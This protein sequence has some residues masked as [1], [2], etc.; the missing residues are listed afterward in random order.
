MFTRNY[1]DPN[2]PLLINTKEFRTLAKDPYVIIDGG[3]AGDIEVPFSHVKSFSKFIRFEPRGADTID[4]NDDIYVDGGLWEE[5]TLKNLHVAKRRTTSS[6][7]PPNEE[8]LKQFDN[9]YGLPPRTTEFKLDVKLRSI[10]SAVK[11]G[12]IPKPN[13]I[14]LDIHS[15]EFEAVKGSINSLDENLGF[16]IE[17]WHSDVH[18]GQHIHGELESFLVSNGYEVFDLRSAASW[19]YQYQGKVT[20][21]D[22]PRYMGSEMLFLRKDVPGHLMIKYIGLCDLFN[23]STL[24]KSKIISSKNPETRALISVYELLLKR[25]KKLWRWNKF[26]FISEIKTIIKYLLLRS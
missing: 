13:F 15:A 17:T 16:L 21:F 18:K 14:K 10:D 8:F 2:N 26:G 22:K 24:A 3:A 19:K 4:L 5:D 23:F 1:W 20:K 12:E 9:R 11:N 25:K 6:I 7:Y